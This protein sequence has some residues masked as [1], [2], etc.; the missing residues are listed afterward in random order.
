MHRFVVDEMVE[1]INFV[2]FQ[3]QSVQL[4]IFLQVGICKKYI[5]LS[6]LCNK[7]TE[8]SLVSWKQKGLFMFEIT[9]LPQGRLFCPGC[10]LVR[11]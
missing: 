8:K 11:K 4:F 5:K 10:S 7:Q 2:H 9:Q 6:H 3:Y 1:L